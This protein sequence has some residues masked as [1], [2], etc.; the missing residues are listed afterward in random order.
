MTTEPP[1]KPAA[2]AAESA[3]ERAAAL[4]PEGTA[5]VPVHGM[6]GDESAA[7]RAIRSSDLTYND[8]LRV[9]DLLNL[10]V[11]ESN[12]PHHDEM[13]F[14]IIH[15]TYELWFKLVLHEIERAMG[16]MADGHHLRARHFINRV[17][18][19]L[20]L[21]V[22]QIHI[23]ETMQP[24]DFLHF[25]HHLMPASGFQSV[26]FRE[27]EFAVG[28]KDPR[29]CTFFNNRPDLRARLEHRLA[30]EDLRTVWSK[31]VH[32]AGFEMPTASF[33]PDHRDD[34]EVRQA[35]VNALIP[36]FQ[37]PDDHMPLYLLFESL[38]A[39]DE[40]LAL[41]R[42]HHVRVVARVIG[43]RPGTG[44]SAGVDYLKS[45]TSKRAF[46]ELWE[47]RTALQREDGSGGSSGFDGGGGGGCP[48]GYGA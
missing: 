40:Y 8:Y 22:Q 41:W 38:I 25:R 29:Y 47:V 3:P 12:P 27:V 9:S 44:G 7:P 14:I 28:L 2:A 34:P 26:Q 10:Q 13:L 31:M 48:M 24:I 45:T 42:E 5:Q 4:T 18:E 20:R 33:D 23:V 46:P 36:V 6:Y 32:S 11:P 30:A 37:R 39:F 15:Q 43:W 21:L 1:Q 35:A 17:V 16:F 19:I